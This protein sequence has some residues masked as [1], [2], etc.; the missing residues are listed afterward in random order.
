MLLYLD[1]T[2]KFSAIKELLQN[3]CQQEPSCYE[4]KKSNRFNKK[5]ENIEE[6]KQNFEAKDKEISNEI[7]NNME[8]SNASTADVLLS[9]ST[10]IFYVVV[11]EIRF[12]I[13]IN[14]SII[15]FLREYNK[16]CKIDDLTTPQ[17]YFEFTHF[18][19][20]ETFTNSFIS[21]NANQEFES[22]D[23]LSSTI[24]ENISSF[25]EKL[26]IKYYSENI[27]A[28]NSIYNV[29]RIS[30]FLYL[31]SLFELCVNTYHDMFN[32]REKLDENVL[33]NFKATSLLTKQIRDPVAISSNSVPIWCKDICQNLPYL[34]SFNSRYLFFRTCS[35][36]YNR[37]MVN[38][39]IFLKNNMG[40]IIVD[41]KTLA[42]Y[43]IRKKYKV[44]RNNLMFFV[45]KIY[46]EV[47]N[48]DV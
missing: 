19:D 43:C 6:K 9:K 1:K 8:V 38:L 25:Q 39:S 23:I 10:I 45:E 18:K 14:W 21:A 3:K 4:N 26:F 29:K 35:F 17:I 20:E 5:D 15:E 12:K 48:F 33:E 7:D 31:I 44:E 13:Y 30:P 27:L 32:F 24:M 46:K 41:E 28:N 47:G 34:A 40:E 36:D 42:S 2:T 11:K 37:S 22:D 16:F